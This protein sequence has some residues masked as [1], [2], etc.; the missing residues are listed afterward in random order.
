LRTNDSGA[1]RQISTVACRTKSQKVERMSKTAPRLEP[2]LRFPTGSASAFGPGKAQLLRHIAATGSIRSAAAELDMSYNRA[3]QLV[4]TMNN[5]FRSP[6]VERSR[7]GD[8]RGGATLTPLGEQVL[9]LYTQM[10]EACVAATRQQW[11]T[12]RGLLQT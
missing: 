9:A 12:L 4:A 2:R 5:L 6:L 3:W 8:S 7:G 11:N 1:A 10:E